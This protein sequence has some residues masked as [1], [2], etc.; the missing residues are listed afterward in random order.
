VAES[1]LCG[2]CPESGGKD[3]VAGNDERYPKLALG[4]ALSRSPTVFLPPPSLMASAYA[5]ATLLTSDAYLPGALTLVSALR[6]LHPSPASPPEV[7]F[8]TVCIVTPETLDVS[9]IKVLRK[10]YDVVVGVEVLTQR[11]EK[12]LNL[13]GM[14][15]SPNAHFN[16]SF[17]RQCCAPLLFASSRTRRSL[18]IRGAMQRLC[19]WLS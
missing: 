8:Q 18:G 10:A 1:R 14:C 16:A 11:D 19:S 4:R 6:D 2:V 7:D 5:F 12:N 17:L 3:F 13:L 9:T 15:N